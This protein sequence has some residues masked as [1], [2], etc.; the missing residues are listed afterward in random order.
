MRAVTDY[1]QRQA[2]LLAADGAKL[3][4]QEVEELLWLIQACPTLERL[5]LALAGLNNA[6]FAV[7]RVWPGLLRG[8]GLD[9]LPPLCKRLISLLADTALPPTPRNAPGFLDWLTDGENVNRNPLY[10][11]LC[12]LPVKLSPYAYRCWLTAAHVFLAQ[13]ALLR[14]AGRPFHVA[15]TKKP[16]K[17]Y[18]PTKANYEAY[19]FAR[20][21]DQ[22]RVPARHAALALRDICGNAR[23]QRGL[24]R[25][26]RLHLP[27]KRLARSGSLTLVA[28]HLS[29][30]DRTWLQDRLDYITCYLEQVYNLKSRHKGHGRT[31][32]QQPPAG[33]VTASPASGPAGVQ[34]VRGVKKGPA[35]GAGGHLE[36]DIEDWDRFDI[37]PDEDDEEYDDDDDSDEDD[38]HDS[39]G[40]SDD[41]DEFEHLDGGSD[42][43]SSSNDDGTA[44]DECDGEERGTPDRT[45]DGEAGSGDG[46]KKSEGSAGGRN[47]AGGGG[48][49]GYQAIRA[50][51]G[52]AFAMDRPAP[53]E[54]APVDVE[55]RAQA[56]QLLDSLL[57]RH[58]ANGGNLSSTP[59]FRRAETLVF[60]L[61][62]LWTGSSAERTCLMLASTDPNC[63]GDAALICVLNTPLEGA[64]FRVRVVFPTGC[65]QLQSRIGKDRFRTDQVDLPDAAELGPLLWKLSELKGKVN[66][67]TST[68]QQA[69]PYRVFDRPLIEYTR[70]AKELLQPWNRTARLTLSSIKSALYGAILSWSGKDIV[71]TTMITGVY[72]GP[73]RVPM[74]YSSR[75]M[76]G[77]QGIYTGTVSA[78][79]HRIRLESDYATSRQAGT[80]QRD[81]VACLEGLRR[82]KPDSSF[83]PAPKGSLHVGSRRCPEDFEMQGA[84]TGLIDELN[85]PWDLT[86][87]AQFVNY[88]NLYTFY[89]I[90]YFG[91][92]TGC[93]P[94]ATPYLSLAEV[95]PITLMAA[96]CDKA[97]EKMRPVWITNRLFEH[98]Q[99]Y[100]KYVEQTSLHFSTAKP[101]WFLTQNRHLGEFRKQLIETFVQKYLPGFPS[102]ISRRWMMNALWDSGCP[103][104]LVRAWAGHATA[105]N[106]FWASGATA[107]YGEIASELRRYIEPILNYLGFVPM[108]G[109]EL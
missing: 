8:L 84:V 89:T 51:K 108:A 62:C 9:Y 18:F 65:A 82:L 1:P 97:D 27:P 2:L 37:C 45:S 69:Q 104:E 10:A 40:Q 34:P 91:F 58:A 36:N 88:T 81:L 29:N 26:L 50:S 41:E 105:G 30:S 12:E 23:W 15:N 95:S 52:F 59:E 75:R 109:K 19:D 80:G 38:D 39:D 49:D 101:C 61:T 72:K 96:L 77:L 20:P 33:A 44:V 42:S 73:A 14:S 87:E 57:D 93:R 106:A 103:P 6:L 102:N 11:A 92:V 85:K 22:I 48:S 107:H 98:M 90:W 35:G 76:A 94:I 43:G 25:S 17:Q 46:D 32:K 21:W 68:D 53:C 83:V 54:L 71:A 70:E 78:L 56:H 5:P 16:G 99:C 100:S 55:G 7:D 67:T 31:R 47:R 4:T 13:V 86:G 64:R 74:F 3:K 60:L 24:L 79:R 66:S 28:P 63:D